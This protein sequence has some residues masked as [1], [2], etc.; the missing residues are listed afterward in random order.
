LITDHYAIALP[1]D[2]AA[3]E[4]QVV[5][6]LYD[7]ETAERLRTSEGEDAVSLTTIEVTQSSE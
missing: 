2:L 7:S 1:G 4:Y 6:G 5:A 3:G